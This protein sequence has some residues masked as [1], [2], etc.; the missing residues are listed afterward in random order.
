[1]RRVLTDEKYI[2]EIALVKSFRRQNRKNFAKGKT[3]L[4]SPAAPIAFY[5]PQATHRGKHR[6][7]AQRHFAAARTV[8]EH[9]FRFGAGLSWRA[10]V[11]KQSSGMRL[12]R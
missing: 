9:T 8:T 11:G 7:W 12:R 6:I 3:N 10:A 4:P 5:F 1:M 2:T